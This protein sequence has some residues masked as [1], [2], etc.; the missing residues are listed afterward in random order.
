MPNATMSEPKPRSGPSVPLYRRKPRGCGGVFFVFIVLIAALWGAG[1]GFFVSLLDEAEAQIALLDDFRPKVG[2]KFYSDP[3]TGGELL[4]EYAVSY[5]QLVSLHEIPLRLQKAFLA[6]EDHRFY[7][8][9]GVR[10]DAILKAALRTLRTQQ[11][12]GGSTIT[13]QIVRNLEPTEV[14]FELTI[15]RKL[16]EALVALKLE[17]QYT[18]DEI[19]ELYLNQIFLGGSAYGVEAASRQYFGK[20]CDE[21][22]LSEAAALAGLTRGPNINRPDKALDKAVARRDVVLA[23]MLDNGFVTQ[24]EHDAAL[25]ED[26]GASVITPEQRLAMLAEGRGFWGPNRFLAP[27][28]VEDVRRE[29]M[30]AGRVTRNDLREGGLEIYTTLDMDLQRAAEAAL[31]DALDEFD[32]SRREQLRRQNRENEF[33]PVS[34][35]L[36]CIDNRPG[37]E[38]FVRALV[39][40]RDWEREK[41]NTVTQARRQPGSSVKPFVWAAAL[42]R[43]MTPSTTIMDTPYVR[44]DRAGN[45]WAPRNFDG[46]FQGPMTLR[47]ALQRSRNVVSVRLVEQVGLPAVK[48]VMQRAGVTSEIPDSVGLTISLGTPT[49]TVLEHCVAYSTFAKNGTYAP[50]VMVKEIRN[51][52]GFVSFKAMPQLEPGRIQPSIAYVMTYLME[53]VCLYGTGTRTAPLAPRPRAGKTGTTNDARDVW[54]AGYTADY[55]CVVWI[56]YRDNRSLGSGSNYTGGRMA[57]PVWTDF[58]LAAHE[59]LPIRDFETPPGVEFHSVDRNSGVRGGGFREAFIEGTEPPVARPVLPEPDDLEEG[60]V[61]ELLGDFAG[62]LLAPM[63]APAPTTSTAPLTPP[64]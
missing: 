24:E 6:T 46:Q 56:G 23:Q 3:T 30:A 61:Q 7:E 10:P 4:G 35:A 31:F 19:L 44:V 64:L 11:V 38:G 53:G 36:V 50:P 57:C 17:Q 2:S 28:F 55:T 34:G 59:N 9:L 26:L 42:E 37:Y 12:H 1:L 5:R 41:F 32:E 48:S 15:R 51:P 49:Y 45:R 14:S 8:H 21:L 60:M 27:Y 25:G 29:L 40:G 22:T 18:K 52:D 20:R 58:M 62:D 43:N 54:F 47:T 39:G 13:Q 16:R 63:G 33:V